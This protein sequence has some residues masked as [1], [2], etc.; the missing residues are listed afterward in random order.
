MP[1]IEVG[2]VCIKTAGRRSGKKAVV[3]KIMDRN[4][5]QVL[6]QGSKKQARCSIRHLEPTQKVLSDTSDAAIGKELSA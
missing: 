3:I 6:V 1:A 5:V 2:R 4:F